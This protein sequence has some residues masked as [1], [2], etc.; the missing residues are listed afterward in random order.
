MWGLEHSVLAL[1]SILTLRQAHA[2]PLRQIERYV[3]IL[4]D[5]NCVRLVLDTVKS[6]SG[7][8]EY[9]KLAAAFLFNAATHPKFAL[10]MTAPDS[11]ASH[12]PIL[13]GLKAILAARHN[14][15]TVH[16]A[17]VC[18]SLAWRTEVCIGFDPSLSH[19]GGGGGG[20]KQCS[21]S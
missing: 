8:A 7:G 9:K 18:H 1:H 14:P 20:S 21:K 12:L 5:M 4:V 13:S 16:C 2:A 15:S 10:P 17:A 3:D 6:T 11:D 19:G